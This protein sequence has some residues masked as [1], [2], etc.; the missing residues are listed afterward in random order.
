M[1]DVISRNTPAAVINLYAE[2]LF[3]TNKNKFLMAVRTLNDW[4]TTEEDEEVLADFLVSKY[5]ADQLEDS[6]AK[7]YYGFGSDRFS[8]KVLSK[9]GLSN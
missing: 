3:L 7:K 1:L 5:S 9:A 6:F 4:N 8:K 2:K